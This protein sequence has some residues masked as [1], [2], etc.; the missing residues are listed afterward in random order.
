[1]CYLHFAPSSGVIVCSHW[2]HGRLTQVSRAPKAG[3]QPTSEHHLRQHKSRNVLKIRRSVAPSA[4]EWALNQGSEHNKAPVTVLSCWRQCE[5]H[6]STGCAPIVT[7]L[8][9]S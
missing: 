3:V 6:L 8:A 7:H 9:L 5:A 2:Q 4:L 1:M